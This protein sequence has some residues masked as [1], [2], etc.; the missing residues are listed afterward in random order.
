[1]TSA[2]LHE[3]TKAHLPGPSSPSSIFEFDDLESQDTYTSD[4]DLDLPMSSTDSPD[5]SPRD[6]TGDTLTPRG[7]SGIRKNLAAFMSCSAPEAVSHVTPVKKPG[8]A[9]G[10]SRKKLKPKRLFNQSTSPPVKRLVRVIPSTKIVFSFV[11]LEFFSSK[12]QISF[13]A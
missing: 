7:R 6:A 12:S 1:M 5:P 8:S 9:I 13:F 11:E 4:E 3:L 10:G 2:E